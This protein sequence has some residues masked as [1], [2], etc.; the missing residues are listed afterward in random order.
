VTNVRRRI[1]G[2]VHNCGIG[3]IFGLEGTRKASIRQ[4][5]GEID[6]AVAAGVRRAMRS[7]AG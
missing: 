2:L 4:Q 5:I 6:A 3:H 1:P 7:I